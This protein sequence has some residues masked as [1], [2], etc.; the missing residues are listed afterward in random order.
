[1]KISDAEQALSDAIDAAI[2]QSEAAFAMFGEPY[3]PRHA[4]YCARTV[5]AWGAAERRLREAEA[6]APCDA[7][8]RYEAGKRAIAAQS[9]TPVEYELMVGE[10]AGRLGV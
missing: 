8:E 10:L 7:W 1:M 6:E 3:G 4:L 5:A 2:D 9:P